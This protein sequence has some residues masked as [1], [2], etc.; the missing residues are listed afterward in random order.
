VGVEEEFLLV[1]PANGQVKAV[2]AAMLMAAM[3]R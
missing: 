1:D 2:G 3:S